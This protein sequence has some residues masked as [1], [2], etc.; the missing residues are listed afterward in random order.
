MLSASMI[1]Q[2]QDSFITKEIDSRIDSSKERILNEQVGTNVENQFPENME[3]ME[4]DFFD[5][6]GESSGYIPVD[7]TNR[8]YIQEKLDNLY[9]EEIPLP[10]GNTEGIQKRIIVEFD[11]I[12]NRDDFAGS[13]PVDIRESAVSFET[14]PYVSLELN[15][16]SADLLK[17]ASGVIDAV[18]DKYQ[19]VVDFDD[20]DL[21][22]D[23]LTNITQ[24]Y[25]SEARIGSNYMYD[26][27]YNGTGVKV[28]VIDTG[29]DKK[30]HDLQEIGNGSTK[31]ISEA[32]F[33]DFDF[34]GNPDD[35]TNDMIGHGTHV[36]GTVAGNGY[37]RGVAPDAY[38]INARALDDT[39]WTYT[40]W[41]VSA[42]EWAVLEAG[43]DIITMSIGWDYRFFGV[44]PA[45]ND[46]VGWAWDQGVVVTVAAANSGP[47]PVSI[48]SPCM[49]PK[50]ITVGATDAHD[51]LAL[52]SSR[53]PQPFG[54]PDPDICAPGV[55]VF[56]CAPGNKY[57]IAS[58]TSM[59]TPHA[60]GAA[61]L[62]LEAHPGVS[63]DQ[64]KTNLMKNAVDINEPRFS[65]G[66]GLINLTAAHE[67]WDDGA[68]IVFP[69]FDSNDA[70]HLSSGE[71]Y[72]GY[73]EFISGQNLGTPDFMVSGGN[74]TSLTIDE[75][76]LVS[77][78]GHQFVPFSLMATGDEG[79]Y[80]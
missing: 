68:A 4:N 1:L 29:I 7:Q 65:Q 42:V 53:G 25:D 40:S 56:S 24:W 23:N 3:E 80:F 45:V 46:I 30:H 6:G 72:R 8:E 12:S 61:A 37:H 36:A 49:S 69:I 76:G 18:A 20:V 31:I 50:I 39:G 48:G 71:L 51:G 41:V 62:L 73:L 14:I 79:D 59:A 38:L 35:D 26:L 10:D 15:E 43:A 67:N 17:E 5:T 74:I 21:Y 2:S 77:S 55:D 63:P 44:I 70:F 75:S 13:L 28:C 57:R 64:I 11:T 9:D 33:I 19:K 52:F 47:D 66:A 60:A 34:D 54:Y 27:G 22:S 58:G 78:A 16:K 32:S